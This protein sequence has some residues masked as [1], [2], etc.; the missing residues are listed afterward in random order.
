MRVKILCKHMRPGARTPLLAKQSR[1]TL[2]RYLVPRLVSG[3][4]QTLS[5]GPQRLGRPQQCVQPHPDAGPCWRLQ[6]R[7]QAC[8]PQQPHSRRPKNAPGIETGPIL[9]LPPSTLGPPQQ[10]SAVA[11]TTAGK[12]CSRPARSSAQCAALATDLSH[13]DAH[14]LRGCRVILL[15]AALDVSL[16][17]RQPAGYPTAVSKA[18]VRFSTAAC[19]LWMSAIAVAWLLSD[20]FLA[21]PCNG[22]KL[23]CMCYLQ[24]LSSEHAGKQPMR[25]PAA[26]S[27]ACP[28]SSPACMRS[29]SCCMHPRA[30]CGR[31]WGGCAIAA[32]V[33]AGAPDQA[34][35]RLFSMT[36]GMG[37]ISVPSSCSMRK[38]LKRSS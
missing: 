10:D 34:Q 16:R 23:P 30:R 36:G 38:R 14:A 27:Q 3:A 12:A 11:P 4:C 32:R 19:G 35:Y 26:A 6:G 9:Y 31:G 13:C 5:A 7:R 8:A 29:A 22:C 33:A 21:A 1:Q 37:L 28:P 17:S 2:S 18:T 20:D 15:P 25:A 24:A